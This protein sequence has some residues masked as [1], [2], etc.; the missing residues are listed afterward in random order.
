[1]IHTDLSQTDLEELKNWCDKA[2]PGFFNF[3][4]ESFMIRKETPHLPYYYRGKERNTVE[5]AVVSICELEN[6]RQAFG[7][8]CKSK[9]FSRL[10]K[11]LKHYES[12]SGE[13]ASTLQ[14]I[15]IAIN[16]KNYLNID[17]TDFFFIQ[18]KR[19]DVYINNHFCVECKA[20]VEIMP[21]KQ[22]MEIKEGGGTY[23]PSILTPNKIQNLIARATTETE[24]VQCSIT[25][26][27]LVKAFHAESILDLEFSIDL[28][29]FDAVVFYERKTVQDLK[30]LCN[31]PTYKAFIISCHPPARLESQIF[32]CFPKDRLEPVFIDYSK[33]IT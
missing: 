32:A 17:P 9:G 2:L 1:M 23:T 24:D 22:Q 11:K 12:N 31:K 19:G 16:I 33:P 25:K 10:W 3:Q 6:L 7:C 26:M 5:S 13:I 28:R 30:E 18:P 14:T 21:R 4:S 29:S 15:D 8:F 20:I 27:L